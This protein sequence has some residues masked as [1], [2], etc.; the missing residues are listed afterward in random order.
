MSGLVITA[1]E[2]HDLPGLAVLIRSFAETLQMVVSPDLNESDLH[3]ILFSQNPYA[4]CYMLRLEDQVIGFAWTEK[5]WS[6]FSASECLHIK[7]LFISLAYQDKGYG[8]HVMRF[9]ADLAT[10]RGYAK[11]IWEV[12]KRNVQAIRFYKKLG[13]QGGDE[14]LE[15]YLDKEGMKRLLTH[16]K[17]KQ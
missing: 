6:I 1:A 12:R 11:I 13:L 17:M 16:A 5:T 9:L 3:K 8:V 10:R 7:D 14:G 2:S 4:E 15:F